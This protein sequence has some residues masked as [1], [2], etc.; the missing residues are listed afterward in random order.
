MFEIGESTEFSGIGI[1]HLGQDSNIMKKTGRILFTHDLSREYNFTEEDGSL[2]FDTMSLKS[3][4][5][6]GK[7]TWLAAITPE[8]IK[9]PKVLIYLAGFKF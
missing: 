2:P 6:Q 1:A 5:L 7:H 8:F 9:M 4:L 3:V